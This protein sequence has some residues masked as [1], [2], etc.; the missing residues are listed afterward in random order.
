MLTKK[1]KYAECASQYIPA[2]SGKIVMISETEK[3]YPILC[4]VD[5]S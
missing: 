3:L 1:K 2:M 5:I 4:Y